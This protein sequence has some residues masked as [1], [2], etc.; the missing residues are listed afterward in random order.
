MI[1]MY[2]KIVIVITIIIKIKITLNIIHLIHG[3]Y[4]KRN[5]F[6]PIKYAFEITRTQFLY[7]K[8]ASDTTLNI[9]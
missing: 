8:C 1:T 6:N 9:P 2:I 4:Q 3:S 5:Q 7:L